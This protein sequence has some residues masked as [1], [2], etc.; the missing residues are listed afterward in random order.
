MF[1]V[2]TGT[3]TLCYRNSETGDKQRG[4]KTVL[5]KIY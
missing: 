4:T 2:M 1:Q 5:K 3:F